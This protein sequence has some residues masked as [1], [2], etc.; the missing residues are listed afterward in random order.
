MFKVFANTSILLTS[1]KQ[2][3]ESPILSETIH[4]MIKNNDWSVSYVNQVPMH[5]I[6]YYL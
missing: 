5:S 6:F 2:P 3:L 4:K 1:S